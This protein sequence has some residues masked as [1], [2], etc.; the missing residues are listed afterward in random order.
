[1]KGKFIGTAGLLFCI[2][3][4]HA[5]STNDDESYF[6]LD[7]DFWW[8]Y[9]IKRTLDN[10]LVEQ[11]YIVANLPAK[12][13]DGELLFPRKA[14]NGTLELYRK[15]D[16]GIARTGLQD[17]PDVWIFKTP[18]QVG[19]RWQE[20]TTLSF[21][22]LP[23]HRKDLLSEAARQVEL[24]YVIEAIDDTVDV[25][26]G[27]FQHCMRIK[28]HG[29]VYANSSLKRIMGIRSIK[30]EHTHWYAPGIGL[31]KSIKRES[32]LPAKYD[33]EYLQELISYRH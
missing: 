11:K 28:A 32:S 16:S 22:D 27:T 12:E 18:L 13:I 7:N 6:P 19:T 33:G 29:F 4:V 21:L 25:A 26:A 15:S 10:K 20:N 2:L 1:M 8:E 23:E 17:K 3:F 5:C 14:A 31:V 24:D 9:A 30:I